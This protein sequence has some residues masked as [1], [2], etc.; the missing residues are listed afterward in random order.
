MSRVQ[1][2]ARLTRVLNCIKS[3]NVIGDL[4]E[5]MLTFSEGL[6]HDLHQS[7]WES[8]NASEAGV[9][10]WLSDLTLTNPHHIRLSEKVHAAW[11]LA[12]SNN[13]QFSIMNCINIARTHWQKVRETMLTI[14]PRPGNG[15]GTKMT[16]DPPTDPTNPPKKK[17]KKNKKGKEATTDGVAAAA[18]K[19]KSLPPQAPKA[20]QRPPT[21]TY[22]FRCG[23]RPTQSRIVRR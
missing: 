4:G 11:D 2:R 1:R 3:N 16:N 10:M 21:P 18:T 15:G 12:E 9:L 22:C 5:H 7:S 23:R 19:D 14:G 20:P 8:M 17:R 6:M 13:Q